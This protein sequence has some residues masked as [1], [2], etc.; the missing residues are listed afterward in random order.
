MT[1]LGTVNDSAVKQTGT[2]RL[3][4]AEFVY[5]CERAYRYCGLDIRPGKEGLVQNRLA[6]LMRQLG[7]SSFREYCGYLEKD[8][9]GQALCAMVDCLTTNYT[10]FFREE[11]QFRFLT[12]TIVPMIE[13]RRH[14]DIWSAACSTGEEPYSL[15]FALLSYFHERGREPPC[16]QILATDISKKALSVAQRAVYRAEKFSGV[17][18]EIVHRYMLRGTGPS[19]GLFC[20]KPAVR[21]LVEFR[22]MNLMEPFRDAGEYPLILCRNVMIYFDGVT[23]ERLIA[24]FYQRLES[25]GFFFT[26]HSESLNRLRQ[27][28]RYVCPAVYRRSGEL[29]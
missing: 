8:K 10:G 7:I 17:P 12:S 27:P 18:K 24:R 15:A 5:I 29:L 19:E 2:P 28:M 21:A 20:V 4:H 13:G 9:D 22:R 16:I 14:I 25:G 11:Q 26:G 3:S 1:S 23:Q 6:R